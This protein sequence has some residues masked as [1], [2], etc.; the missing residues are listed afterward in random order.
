VE[1]LNYSYIRSSDNILSFLGQVVSTRNYCKLVGRCVISRRECSTPIILTIS[2][3]DLL[4]RE[5]GKG[6]FCPADTE[7]S[8]IREF[9]WKSFRGRRHRFPLLVCV[10]VL[11]DLRNASNQMDLITNAAQAM[12]DS[13]IL[14]K[15]ENLPRCP[16]LAA[17]LSSCR[18][19]KMIYL[20]LPTRCGAE[21]YHGL[22]ICMA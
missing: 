11:L 3:H 10:G 4:N 20:F 12:D 8:S 21:I 17:A 13:W 19:W 1:R 5:S 14:G 6:Q 22:S 2:Q 16:G 7:D 15:V 9:Q 18:Q